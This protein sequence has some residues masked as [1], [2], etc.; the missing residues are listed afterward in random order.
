MGPGG[1]GGT[2]R[3]GSGGAHPA[4][5]V[6]RAVA[7]TLAPPLRF[8]QHQHSGQVWVWVCVMRM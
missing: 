6:A 4:G 8:L 2:A 3:G 5:G 1:G 7:Q